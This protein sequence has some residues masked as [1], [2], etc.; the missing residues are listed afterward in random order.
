ML[1]KSKPISLTGETAVVR[2]DDIQVEL[3]GG[4]VLAFLDAEVELE[5]DGIDWTIAAISYG[6]PY[7][8]IAD[9]SL[10]FI[11][12]NVRNRAND[13]TLTHMVERVILKA[14]SKDYNDLCRQAD[15]ELRCRNGGPK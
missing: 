5:H 4:Y 6:T 12:D 14:A 7:E 2:L 10:S 11:A 8:K 9:T 1:T 15:D 13:E 3:A